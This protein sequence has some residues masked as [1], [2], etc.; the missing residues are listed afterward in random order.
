MYIYIFI[1]I[2]K[3]L[4]TRMSWPIHKKYLY[5]FVAIYDT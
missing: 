3:Y 1:Y 2:I 4:P 5:K